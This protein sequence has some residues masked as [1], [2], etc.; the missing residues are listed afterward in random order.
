VL[1]LTVLTDMLADLMSSASPPHPSPSHHQAVGGHILAH[2]STH[3]LYVRKGKAEQRVIKVTDSPGLG[4]W[5]A[6]HR[7]WAKCHLWSLTGLSASN[8]GALCLGQ[9][10]CMQVRL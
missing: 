6:A 10:T 8:L 9:G 1:H 4:E 2:T 5:C 3:R 7:L